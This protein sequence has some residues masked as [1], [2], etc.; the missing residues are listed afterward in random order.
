VACTVVSQTDVQTI[1]FSEVLAEDWVYGDENAHVTIMEYADFQCPYCAALYPVLTQLQQEYPDDVR[2]VYRHYP[3]IGT[4]DE[5]IHDKA[6]LGTQ[7]AEAA[8]VQ[9]YFWQMHDILF[10]TQD[11]WTTMSDED[12]IQ[13]VVDAAGQLGMDAGQ[14]RADMLSESMAE[15]AQANWEWGAET[16]LPGTPFVMFNGRY[17]DGPMNKD[18]LK[19]IIDLLL[20]EK[21]Q[22]ETCPAITID[23][24]NTYI[25]TL[26]TE[27]GDIVIELLDDIAPFT[28]NNFIFLAENDWYDNSPFHRVLEGF[29]AQGGDPSGTGLG[30]PGYMFGLEVNN[31][32]VFDSAGLLAMA[33]AGANANGSQFFITYG[34]ATHLNGGFTIFG[35]VLEGMDVALSLTRRNPDDGPGQPQDYLLDVTIDV[36]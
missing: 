24:D 5:P 18:S 14:F 21:R 9:G 16:G 22:F 13:Y 1:P 26:H 35:E 17:Y 4:P 36:Q 23:T 12:F 8:G 3:L 15:F 10:E 6:A 27:K 25:A 19:A 30:N 2:I 31:D 20:L 28:V 29:M 7:A 34:P 11:T 33:N 32:L